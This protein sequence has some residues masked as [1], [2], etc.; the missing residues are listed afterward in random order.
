MRFPIELPDQP[1]QG[2]AV[3]ALTS[4][5]ADRLF[6][7]LDHDEVWTHI[8]GARPRTPAE[9][10]ARLATGDGRQTTV[11]RRGIAVVGT[12]SFYVD[13]SD[14]S[15]VEIGST[16]LTPVVWGT[17]L[18]TVVKRIMLTAAFGAGAEWVRL[19]TDERN[20]RSAAAILKVPGVTETDSR[21]EPH[22]IR[23]D[24]STRISRM[25]RIGRPDVTHRS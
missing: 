25:F 12:S 6:A 20:H 14:P 10:D 15:G 19:R 21:L 4:D 8:P 2:I 18:N 23:P 5:D 13:P 24:G 22:W 17:G 3:A 1:N 11:I 9:L 7:V 16:L